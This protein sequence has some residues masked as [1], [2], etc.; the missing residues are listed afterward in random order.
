MVSASG[1]SKTIF[2]FP[3]PY[4]ICERLKRLLQQKQADKNSNLFNDEIVAIVDKL[5]QCKCISKKQHN[6]FLNKCNLLDE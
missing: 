6:Q 3:D 5:L 4:E 1:V 2:L